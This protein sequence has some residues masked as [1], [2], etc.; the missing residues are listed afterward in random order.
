MFYGTKWRNLSKQQ[1]NYNENTENRKD[2]F[3]FLVNFM[4]TNS[5]SLPTVFYGFLKKLKRIS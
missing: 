5:S 4:C 3:H 1:T 2:L